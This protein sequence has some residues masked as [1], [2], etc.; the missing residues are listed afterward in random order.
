MMKESKRITNPN[1]VRFLIENDIKLL[2]WRDIKKALDRTEGPYRKQAR[3]LILTLYYTGARPNEVLRLRPKDFD[4][5]K[6]NW[7]RIKVPGSKRGMPRILSI[8]LTLPGISELWDYSQSFPFEDFYIFFRYRSTHKRQYISKSGA[9]IEYPELSNRLYY[10]FKRWFKDVL[11]DSIPPYYLRHNRLSALAQNGA[12]LTDLK[13][14]KG[15]RRF[16]SIEPYVHMSSESSERV[17]KI[18]S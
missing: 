10:H 17:G 3:A 16:A 2:K 13:N 8:P 9:T 14:W 4:K 11:Q 18:L 12:S 5:H 15:A 6:T 1:Y 7:V